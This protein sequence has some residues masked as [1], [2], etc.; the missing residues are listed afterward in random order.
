MT[1]HRR[2]LAHSAVCCVA[3]VSA[4][5][6]RPVHLLQSRHT[7]HPSVAD[8]TH[9]A[10]HISSASTYHLFINEPVGCH[11]FSNK[12]FDAAPSHKH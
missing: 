7:P 3:S 11:V 6:A 9:E 4:P 1:V 2:T 12:N 8:F 5:A 10:Y